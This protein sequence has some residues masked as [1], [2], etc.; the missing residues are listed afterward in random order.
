MQFDSLAYIAL[1][2]GTLLAFFQLNATARTW[3]LIA[4]SLLFYATWSIPFTGL[5]VL[6]A[7]I[8]YTAALAIHGSRTPRRRRAFLLLSLVSNLGLLGYFKYA[9]FFLD[10][11]RSVLGDSAAADALAIVLPPGISFYTFQ[12]MSYTIDVYRRQ[13]VPTRSFSRMFLF[14]TFFPQLVAGPIERAGHLLTQFECA[15]RHRFRVE[16]FVVGA[17]MIVWGLAKKV[18][19][20]DSCARLVDAAYADPAGYDGWSLMVATYA[21]TLQ[22]YF[23]FSAYSEIARG[24]ARLFGVDLMRNFDQP[25][26]VT[27]VS[28]FWRRWHISLST[29]IRDYVYRPLGGN[30]GRR[31]RKHK[32]RRESRSLL[33]AGLTVRSGHVHRGKRGWHEAL[34]R[35]KPKQLVRRLVDGTT[36]PGPAVPGEEYSRYAST[37][38][39]WVFA[40]MQRIAVWSPGATA[41]QTTELPEGAGAWIAGFVVNAKDDVYAYGV[42]GLDRDATR[43]GYIAHYDGKTWQAMDA[44][45]CFAGISRLG[46]VVQLEGERAAAPRGTARGRLEAGHRGWGAA[47]VLDAHTGVRSRERR[48][49][50]H[51]IETAD[52]GG[53]PLRT[54]LHDH[55]LARC[56]GVEPRE[57]AGIVPAEHRGEQAQ[58]LGH[59]RR[60]EASRGARADVGLEL[61]PLR[62]RVVHVPQ[63]G[64]NLARE[65][66]ALD[67]ATQHGGD[68]RRRQQRRRAG[69]GQRQ[70]ID[71]V[72]GEHAIAIVHQ[73]V[74]HV[75]VDHPRGGHDEVGM[76]ALIAPEARQT[77][78]R[79][80]AL[81]AEA[82][83]DQ[84]I[85]GRPLPRPQRPVL[86]LL[87]LHVDA[88]RE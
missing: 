17:R 57:R 85:R 39:G 69:P 29:W 46:A 80:R 74:D 81:G 67:H 31:C 20:A 7:V 30:R 84:Q 6:S 83:D 59:H 32:A 58:A 65:R 33:G 26:L 42:R 76:V 9:G 82:G 2:G 11:L 43:G 56:G 66:F 8:D 22:I 36:T 48:G 52:V 44:P 78:H 16:N 40:A 5:I 72:A 1:L 47:A 3:L 70:P 77:P 60:C 27:N 14:V 71:E 4:A 86:D 50:T 37:P 62:Q 73:H 63:P 12:T 25:Y 21:F 45:P 10:N 49:G 41:W 38:D 28:D 34:E 61:P 35:A 18:L 68:G 88:A 53:E 79:G 15:V 51:A 55:R 87:E 24:S 64:L 13:L 54:G 23:D 75:A 19:V